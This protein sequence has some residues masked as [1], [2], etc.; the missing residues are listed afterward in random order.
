MKRDLVRT[1][2]LTSSFLSC[3]K[4][5]ETIIRRLFIDNQPYSNEL[6]RLLII[7]NPDCLQDKTNPEYIKVINDISISDMIKKGYIELD[8]KLKF[9]E[10]EEIR[11]FICI[12]YDNF[13]TNPTN[14]KFRD[15]TINFDIICNYD[16]WNLGNFQQRP[17]KIAGY[18]DGLLNNTRLSGIGKLE[19]VAATDIP[20]PSEWGGITMMYRAVHGSDDQIPPEEE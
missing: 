10:H 11:S 6:K 7:N 12:S 4:D 17:Y 5:T 2:P 9:H 20:L 19:F 18:I 16:Q 1:E 3:E 15:C 14:P 13:V 8:P